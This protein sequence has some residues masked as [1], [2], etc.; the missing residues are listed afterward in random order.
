MQGVDGPDARFHLAELRF[1]DGPAVGGIAL[2][3]FLFL[4]RT[5]SPFQH[6]DVLA[7]DLFELLDMLI[8]RPAIPGP[9]LGPGVDV[10]GGRIDTVEHG[11]G[12]GTA[13]VVAHVAGPGNG[14]G[15][16]LYAADRFVEGVIDKSGG[17]GVAAPVEHVE[18]P[19]GHFGAA[20]LVFLL[21][22][23]WVYGGVELNQV[24][25]GVAGKRPVVE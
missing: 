22:E 14:D 5:A 3:D 1:A 4:M 16:A 10:A 15:E 25:V 20:F 13:K 2:A 19:G 8:S 23:G 7:S 9:V 12:V 24:D 17:F 21:G 18:L 6:S 11:G